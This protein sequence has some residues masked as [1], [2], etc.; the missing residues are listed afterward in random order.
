M[1]SVYGTQLKRIKPSLIR[2]LMGASFLLLAACGGGSGLETAQLS[3]TAW[4]DLDGDGT[5]GE[6]EPVLAD[7]TVFLDGNADG[8]LDEGEVSTT[9][10][11]SGNYT[12]TNLA[13]GTYTVSQVLPLGWSNTL[14][15]SSVGDLRPQVVGGQDV[16]VESYPWM[17]GIVFTNGTLA[18]DEESGSLA[19]AQGCGGSLIAP[20]WVLSAAHCFFLGEQGTLTLSGGMEVSF[21]SLIPPPLGTITPDLV[22]IASGCEVDDFTASVE[23]S[24]VVMPL[25][26][27]DDCDPFEQ[28]LNATEAGSVGVIFYEPPPPDMAGDTAGDIRADK[29]STRRAFTRAPK[30]A[31]P[32]LAILIG[33]E[34]GE[35]IVDAL[36]TTSLTAT[37][38]D[39]LEVVLEEPKNILVLLGQDN[40]NETSPEALGELARVKAIYSHPDYN[41]QVSENADY[42]LLELNE[43]VMRPRVSLPEAED[44]NLTEAGRMATVIGWGSTIGY[45]PDEEDAQAD[46]PIQLQG[47]SLPLVSNADCNDVYVTLIEEL[48]GERLPEGTELIT[49]NMLCAGEPEGGFDSC[50]GDS[51]GPLFVEEAGI[52]FQVGV[53]SFGLGCATPGIPGVYARLPSPASGWVETTVR[54]NGGIERSGSYTATLAGSERFTFD[55]GNFK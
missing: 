52:A 12:F 19:G 46:A 15:A 42:A 1:V 47:V 11:E 10:D 34:D 35:A 44:T 18:F 53:V 40:L 30:Q 45:A 3:G 22:A 23:S 37:F 16:D 51:G 5:R 20:R 48:N 6:G 39:T 8:V 36:E 31:Q 55:F 27:A 14:P 13:A 50:Q 4:H 49:D 17:A 26:G 28:Y 7:W 2:L 43:A 33:T 25:F 21:L 24:V 41:P 54:D 38:G 32:P 29:A 9:T